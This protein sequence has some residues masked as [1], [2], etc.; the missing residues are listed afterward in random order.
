MGGT[1]PNNANSKRIRVLIGPSAIL[2]TGAST[3]L[4]FLNWFIDLVIIRI[5]SDSIKAIGT[6]TAKS[7]V[8]D[9]FATYVQV[10]G[11]DFT[12]TITLKLVAN[13]VGANDVVQEVTT[14]SLF[15][16]S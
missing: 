5:D 12:N 15:Q 13:G 3:A 8:T 16:T 9:V 7:S 14:F 11:L 10:N 6:F 2:D 4:N 1:I